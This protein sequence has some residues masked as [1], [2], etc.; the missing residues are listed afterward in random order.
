MR[1]RKGKKF[2]FI[3]DIALI[4]FLVALGVVEIINYDFDPM[5]IIILVILVGVIPSLVEKIK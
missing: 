1:I 2:W 5:I 3:L 4:V